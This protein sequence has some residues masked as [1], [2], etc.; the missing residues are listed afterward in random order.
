MC[1]AFSSAVSVC[2]L[3]QCSQCVQPSAVQSVHVLG[4]MGE[5]IGNELDDQNRS[6]YA[7]AACILVGV[8]NCVVLVCHFRK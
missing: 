2:S 6:V 4:Q 7:I 5:E 1:A 8:C 3:Q